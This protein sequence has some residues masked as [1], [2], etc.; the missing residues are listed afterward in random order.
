M[1]V[2]AYTMMCAL[3]SGTV[4]ADDEDMEKANKLFDFYFKCES[5]KKC[6]KAGQS[7]DAGDIERLTTSLNQYVEAKG[8]A[9]GG[10]RPRM[11]VSKD[12]RGRSPRT[13]FIL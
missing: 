6:A 11:A 8:C 1:R 12:S 5:V 4:L 13:P 10:S 2:I 7:F 9:A 3:L